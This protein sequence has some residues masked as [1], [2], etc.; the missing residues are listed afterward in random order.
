MYLC[1]IITSQL[2]HWA[3]ISVS[4]DLTMRQIKSLN[5]LVI[6][7]SLSLLQWWETKLTGNRTWSEETDVTA[8]AM[9]IT[10]DHCTWTLYSVWIILKTNLFSS[11]SSHYLLLRTHN[12]YSYL[13]SYISLNS[14]VCYC[15]MKSK[16]S[17]LIWTYFEH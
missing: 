9:S 11:W 4:C 13:I 3:Y 12:F 6:S 10:M 5:A 14:A 15:V 7:S 17:V 8:P 16:S 2:V 1:L